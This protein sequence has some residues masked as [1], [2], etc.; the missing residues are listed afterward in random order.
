MQSI[1]RHF[2]FQPQTYLHLCLQICTFVFPVL[3]SHQTCRYFCIYANTF[4]IKFSLWIKHWLT[5]MLH[6]P[7]ICPDNVCGPVWSKSNDLSHFEIVLTCFFGHI[8]APWMKPT[9]VF[10][11]TCFL[12]LKLW[13]AHQLSYR[14]KK[15]SQGEKS[16]EEFGRRSWINKYLFAD[17]PSPTACGSGQTEANGCV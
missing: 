12:L 7:S 9:L 13:R 8:R 4:T 14:K 1:Q 17:K 2:L 16:L 11:S 5:Q 3:F 10:Y 6:Q 15:L